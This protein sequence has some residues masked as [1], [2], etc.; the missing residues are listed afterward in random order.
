MVSVSYVSEEFVFFF[1]KAFSFLHR[2]FP[3]VAIVCLFRSLPFVLDT[4]LAFLISY[5]VYSYLNGG[6]KS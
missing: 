6:L 4:F 1:F 2:L 5:I 3:Q